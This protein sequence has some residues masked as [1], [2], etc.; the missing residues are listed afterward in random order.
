MK[1]ILM[2]LPVI[3]LM[4]SSISFADTTNTPNIRVSVLRYTP[5]PAE[6]GGYVTLT[7]KVENTGTGDTD[8]VMLKFSPEYPFSMDSNSSVTIENSATPLAMGSDMTVSLGKLP[9]S[10]YMIVDYTVRV[11]SDAIERNWNINFWDQSKLGDSWVINSFNVL[12]QGTDKL[13]I[14]D[15]RPF[16]LSPGQPTDVVFVINNS[17][18]AYVRNVGFS[19]TEANNK[20][21]PLGSGNKKY[22]DEIPPHQT[23]EVPFILVADPGIASGA[24]NLNANLAYTIGTNISKT[25]SVNVGM[26]VGGNSQFDVSAQDSQSGSVSLSIANIGSNPATSVSV[27]IPQQEGFFAS[28]SV[29]SFVGNLNPGDFTLVSFQLVSR[30]RNLTGVAPGVAGR[31]GALKVDIAYTDTNSKRQVIEKNVSV[32]F[33]PSSTEGS[34][35]FQQQRQQ[36]SGMTLVIIGIA[37]IVIVILLIKYGSRI[38]KRL[39]RKK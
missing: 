36:N 1:K 20:I 9:A 7:L 39:R 13:E 17:G 28:G 18:T 23:A 4:V 33:Q 2:I 31:P 5:F 37:G 22:I 10:Q 26:F 35:S 34:T 12:V 38:K 32:S 8:N 11:A 25:T 19:W 29:T 15:V 27:S 21:L 6:P 30:N 3:L 16:T 14:S 24:Y